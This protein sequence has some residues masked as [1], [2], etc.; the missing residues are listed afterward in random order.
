[1]V[2][3]GVAVDVGVDVEVGLGAETQLVLFASLN[4]IPAGQQSII[5]SVD[6]ETLLHFFADGSALDTACHEVQ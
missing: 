6:E 4:T 1:M 5:C 3:F 2:G